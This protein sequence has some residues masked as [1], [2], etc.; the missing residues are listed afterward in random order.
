[1]QRAGQMVA[2]L[3]LLA[4]TLAVAPGPCFAADK[5]REDTTAQDLTDRDFRPPSAV[6]VAVLPFYC[7]KGIER[8][9]RA[10]TSAIALSLMRCGF[11]FA[12]QLET[13]DLPG[14]ATV[15]CEAQKA[16]AVDGNIR[17][18]AA[19]KAEDA[20]R[21]G[22]VLGADWVVFGE[23]LDLHSFTSRTL[24]AMVKKGTAT[25]R[26]EIAE[27]A[28]GE[29]ILDRQRQEKVS[30]GPGLIG[31]RKG[32]ALER[33]AAQHCLQRLY[34]DL[35]AALP[36]H[37]HDP[38]KDYQDG[39]VLSVQEAWDAL[40]PEGTPVAGYQPP[41]QASAPAAATPSA[42]DETGGDD[43]ASGNHLVACVARGELSVE[44]YA[45]A[46]GIPGSVM[47]ITTNK[48]GTPV[49]IDVAPGTVFITGAEGYGRVAARKVTAAQS[50]RGPR[51]PTDRI[52]LEAHETKAFYLEA[53]VL[54]MKR[55]FPPA[56]TRLQ[57]GRI[58]DAAGAVLA[59]A[60]E[61]QLTQRVT[62]AALWVEVDGV[63]I[64]AVAARLSL[65]ADEVASLRELELQ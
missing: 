57:M 64:E 27:V 9:T 7:G 43:T 19:L 23:I 25:I 54:E 26:L 30:A 48:K 61:K 47:A 11:E 65:D 51:V 63:S 45:A 49:G 5:G 31:S 32:T 2:L 53:Y 50:A 28:S 4:M 12:P 16:V 42:A 6:K 62:Q 20:V 59:V 40:L 60:S 8:Q 1:M 33:D 37:R 14:L 52:E 22:R 29:L 38:E 56:D 44:A 18:G 24:L 21:V 41:T 17:P 39:A 58:D 10:A 35:C 15:L 3:A 46:A 13:R 34:A 36:T 55:E